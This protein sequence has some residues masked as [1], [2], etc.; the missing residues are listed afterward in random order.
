MAQAKKRL[1]AGR[2]LSQIKRQRQDKK[3]AFANLQVRSE[4]KTFIK[5]VRSAIEAKE[6][7]QAAT[8]LK[9]ASRVIQK[10]INKGVL[11]K[12]NAARKI[13]R[14]AHQVACL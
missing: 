14:L 4:V 10:A 5:K 9:A 1:P 2:H 12:N 6:K 7:D 8:E 13:S 3:K 11:H